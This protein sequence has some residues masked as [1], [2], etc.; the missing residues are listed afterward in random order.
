MLA[1]FLSVSSTYPP[2]RFRSYVTSGSTS[3]SPSSR[4]VATCAPTLWQHHRVASLSDSFPVGLVP[5]IAERPFW[6]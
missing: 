4:M 1:R 6:I 2:V 5:E 3:I